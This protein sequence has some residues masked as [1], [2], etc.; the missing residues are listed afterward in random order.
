VKKTDLS[1]HRPVEQM[2]GLGR[3]L[4]Q[5]LAAFFRE[6][7]LSFRRQM[8]VA[9]L[10]RP[11]NELFRCHNTFSTAA[12]SASRFRQTAIDHIMIIGLSV[13]RDGTE[14]SAFDLHGSIPCCDGH[15]GPLRSDAGALIFR[16]TMALRRIIS[17]SQM[18]LRHSPR[19]LHPAAAQVALSLFYAQCT[20]VRTPKSLLW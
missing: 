17:A 16:K 20:S 14:C 9:H 13:D 6:I 18:F 2:D 10:A 12:S 5:D 11:N 8:H 4:Q 15:I 19:T 7:G 1:C 3:R